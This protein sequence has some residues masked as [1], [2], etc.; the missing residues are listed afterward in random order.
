MSGTTHQVWLPH[1]LWYN[2]PTSNRQLTRNDILMTANQIHTNMK[3]IS[4]LSAIELCNCGFTVAISDVFAAIMMLNF[5]VSDTQMLVTSWESHPY[6]VILGSIL[7]QARWRLTLLFLY[8]DP[9]ENKLLKIVT[10][11]TPICGKECH[12]LGFPSFSH[13]GKNTTADK[14]KKCSAVQPPPCRI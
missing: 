10:T 11:A 14:S 4:S 1:L 5:Y 7:I 8:N 2:R 3:K 6:T 13:F 9:N 12:M